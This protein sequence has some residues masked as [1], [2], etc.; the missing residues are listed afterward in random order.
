MARFFLC[1]YQEYFE[2]EITAP[3]RLIGSFYYY[4][5]PQ[6]RREEELRLIGRRN[7]QSGTVGFDP[8]LLTRIFLGRM[9]TEHQAIIR[10]WAQR[11]TDGL[12][13]RRTFDQ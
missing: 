7:A 8:A 5:T 2:A 4:K 6:W 1:R 3:A 11:T 13:S 12:V 9:L 10:E